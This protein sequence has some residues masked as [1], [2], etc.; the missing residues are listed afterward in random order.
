MDSE[1]LWSAF[2]KTGSP[3]IYLLFAEARRVEDFHVSDSQG[4]GSACLGLQ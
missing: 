2:L 3:E 1:S 4:I